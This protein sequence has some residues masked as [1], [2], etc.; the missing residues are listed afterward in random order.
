MEKENHL[1][2]KD[3]NGS[4]LP[5]VLNVSIT[6]VFKAN[7]SFLVKRETKFINITMQDIWGKTLDIGELYLLTGKFQY[8]KFAITPCTWRKK[9]ID[10]TEVQKLGVFGQYNKFCRCQIVPCVNGR[11]CSL[12]QTGCEWYIS[13]IQD[14]I[15][16][17]DCT[18]QNAYC[19]YNDDVKDCDWYERSFSNNNCIH[20]QFPDP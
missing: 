19:Q 7:Q 2:W 11:K 16:E 6:D 4:V 3:E 5:R 1:R 9:W 18:S 14:A 20:Q 12:S 10:L 8:G 15:E 13:N 17:K